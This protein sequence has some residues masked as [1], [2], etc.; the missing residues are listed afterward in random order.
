[1][2]LAAVARQ[3]IVAPIGIATSP[4]QNRLH[5]DQFRLG[6]KRLLPRGGPTIVQEQHWAV[7]PRTTSAGR[8]RPFL[9]REPPAVT[10]RPPARPDLQTPRDNTTPKLVVSIAS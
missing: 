5:N 3:T 7:G 2:S 10:I 6:S 9:G 8:L 4:A 1:M